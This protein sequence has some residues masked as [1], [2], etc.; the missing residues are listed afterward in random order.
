MRALCQIV[1]CHAD[2]GMEE[3]F[4]C[5]STG[6]RNRRRE[7]ADSVRRMKGGMDREKE[8]DERRRKEMWNEVKDEQA[9]LGGCEV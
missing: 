6:T 3:C 4:S 1:L 9:D 2:A 7:T 8:R 5:L